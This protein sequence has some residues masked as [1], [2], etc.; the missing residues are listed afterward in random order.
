[1][2]ANLYCYTVERDWALEHHPRG[3][4]GVITR[5]IDDFW[6]AEM[7]PPPARLY[8]MEY[9]QT[10]DGKGDKVIYMGVRVEVRQGR[11]HTVLYDR[12]EEYPYHIVRYPEWTTVAPKEQLG[13]VLMGRF[14]ACLEACTWMTDFKESV[15]NVLRRAVSRRYPYRLVQ[16]VWSKFLHTRWQAGDI[17]RRELLVWLREAYMRVDNHYYRN[18]RP[19]ETWEPI[20]SRTTNTDPA[21]PA[22]PAPPPAPPPP[23]PPPADDGGVIDLL[24]VDLMDDDSIH[25]SSQ[26]ERDG[27]SAQE[28][29]RGTQ[30]NGGTLSDLNDLNDWAWEREDSEL[31]AES[32][33][34][35]QAGEGQEQGR[36]GSIGEG[37]QG[38]T[39]L[40]AELGDPE[41]R[42][43]KADPERP[44]EVLG[45]DVYA[46][47]QTCI[48]AYRRL[49][50][51]VHPD[52]SSHPKAK[53]ASAA[54]AE[55]IRWKTDTAAWRVER[56]QRASEEATARWRREQ[57]AALLAEGK[58]MLWV[59]LQEEEA[60]LYI[61]L[62]EHLDH[63]LKC[64]AAERWVW[65]KGATE[66]RRG[67]GP[68][69]QKRRKLRHNGSQTVPKQP[70]TRHPPPTKHRAKKRREQG[71][72]EEEYAESSGSGGERR[73]SQRRL[74]FE[75]GSDEPERGQKERESHNWKEG[76]RIGEAS[77]PGPPRVGGKAEWERGKGRRKGTAGYRKGGKG[78]R[79]GAP[80]Y[81][82]GR[83]DGRWDEGRGWGGRNPR[84]WGRGPAPQPH[85]PRTQRSWRDVVLESTQNHYKGGRSAHY[86]PHRNEYRDPR[87]WRS[88]SG[89]HHHHDQPSAFREPTY[90]AGGRPWTNE[91]LGIPRRNWGPARHEPVWGTHSSSVWDR[92]QCRTQQPQRHSRGDYSSSNRAGRRSRPPPHHAR[93]T[94][95]PQAPCNGAYAI[96]H[97]N[98]WD[99]LRQGK[100]RSHVPGEEVLA[101]PSR[102]ADSPI[103]NCS[104]PQPVKPQRANRR[105][106]NSQRA[107]SPQSSH[108]NT[109]GQAKGGADPRR[110]LAWSQGVPIVCVLYRIRTIARGLRIVCCACV[111]WGWA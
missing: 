11:V 47:E 108:L 31:S 40:D 32:I 53:E 85:A 17:R 70:A 110:P 96:E 38:A 83:E 51:Q 29:D 23:P 55:A 75:S 20:Y 42:I 93:T 88:R 14:T 67:S 12:E 30:G 10:S 65:E 34:S 91:P 109:H 48:R 58:P 6:S 104:S 41:W 46:D 28:E 102:R 71:K 100:R 106:R 103:R 4:P 74:W 3:L 87:A 9:I 43:L 90:V 45:V 78:G 99:P 7:S 92:H 54:L 69:P 84:G 39:V 105:T 2:L 50:A 63:V 73:H 52:K 72:R 21:R 5:F 35:A 44:W 82:E 27:P 64:E 49:M 57:W 36:A 79:K 19:G 101:R 68:H 89:P 15:I 60:R 62:D 80:G 59:S 95:Y 61:L 66:E 18:P 98:Y 25:V 81:G 24:D 111:V 1:M 97:T 13:G 76:T 33:A 16:S 77:N 8:E 22:R 86:Q 94:H 37:E 56:I 26:G 107:R